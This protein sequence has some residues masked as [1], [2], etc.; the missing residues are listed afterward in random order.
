MVWRSSSWNGLT[1]SFCRPSVSTR[2]EFICRWLVAVHSHPS[3]RYWASMPC[4][5]QKLPISS[6]ADSAA[7]Q[8]RRAS[9]SPQIV[10]TDRYLPHQLVA[11]PP[12]RPLAP[13]PQRSRSTM[14]MVFSGWAVFRRMADHRPRKPPPTMHTSA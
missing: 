4:A 2:Q 9:T 11:T 14:T 6:M 3:L 12:L 13:E 7:W 1:S 10:R 8:M 5:W